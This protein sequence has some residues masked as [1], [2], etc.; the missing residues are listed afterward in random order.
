[1]W[2]SASLTCFV[3]VL[4]EVSWVHSTSG[5]Y[6]N[7]LTSLFSTFMTLFLHFECT[8]LHLCIICFIRS[9][10]N[11]LILH[12]FVEPIGRKCPLGWPKIGSQCFKFF[13]EQKTWAE[14]EVWLT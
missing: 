14:A 8:K 7:V 11:A 5:K 4:N 12:L 6:S 10:F 2:I 1:M 9:V 3:L 13:K